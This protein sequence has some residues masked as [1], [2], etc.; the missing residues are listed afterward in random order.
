MD[1]KW[2]TSYERATIYG[3]MLQFV[4]YSPEIDTNLNIICFPTFSGHCGCILFDIS[5]VRSARNSTTFEKALM[6]YVE[7]LLSV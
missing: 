2:L 4:D 7:N 1:N 6:E 5:K 3:E